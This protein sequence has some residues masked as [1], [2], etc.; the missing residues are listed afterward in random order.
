MKMNQAVLAGVM[1][2]SAALTACASQAY[3]AYRVPAPPPAPYV[4]GAVGYA[5]GPGYGWVDGFWDLRGGRWVWVGGEWRRPPRPR[6]VWV[7]SYWEPYGRSYRFHRG[8]WR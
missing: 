4:V 2:A 5:P 3:V 8:Y 6:A 1:L 7:R